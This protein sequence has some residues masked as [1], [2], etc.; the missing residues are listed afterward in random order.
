MKQVIFVQI[1]PDYTPTNL[2]PFSKNRKNKIT[3]PTSVLGQPIKP[4]Q[5]SNPKYLVYIC[6]KTGG[7]PFL[8]PWPP[9]SFFPL[10]A[11]PPTSHLPLALTT[12]AMCARTPPSLR[13]MLASTR[14]PTHRPSAS[15]WQETSPGAL[16]PAPPSTDAPL[17]RPCAPPADS[18]VLVIKHAAVA[19]G[20]L[21]QSPDPPP[22]R[23]PTPGG[24]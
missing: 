20:H 17:T 2:V 11:S 19:L 7:N 5:N 1:R 15:P 10:P 9:H 22:H 6:I 21:H 13:P 18:L 12:H 14:P 16:A 8:L 23:T 3:K 4:T 24:A